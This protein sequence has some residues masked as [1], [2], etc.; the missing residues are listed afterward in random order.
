MLD[1]QTLGPIYCYLSTFCYVLKKR[2]KKSQ[3]RIHS[4]LLNCRF[5]RTC[6]LSQSP[7]LKPSELQAEGKMPQEQTGNEDKCSKSEIHQS[8]NRSD[9]SR[10]EGVATYEP[11]YRP[12]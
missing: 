4:M 7:D 2:P 9:V 11:D 10:L 1:D 3:H 5:A 12:L 6:V 8:R